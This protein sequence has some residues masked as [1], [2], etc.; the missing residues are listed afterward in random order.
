MI[1]S[2]PSLATTPLDGNVT[3][4]HWAAINNRIQIAEYLLNK[5]AQIDA[6]GGELHSTPLQWAARNGKLAMVVF[7]LSRGA[8]VSIIDGEGQINRQTDRTREICHVLIHSGFSIIHLPAVFG[9][10]DILAYLIARGHEIDVFD[11]H[12]MTPLMHA[13]DKVKQ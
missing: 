8:D 5:N 10:T 6:I 11:E 2:N 7:L 12:G 9:H 1:E 4:L 3:L 13:A